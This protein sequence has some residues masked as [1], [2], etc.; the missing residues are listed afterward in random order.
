VVASRIGK[1]ALFI[2]GAN[3]HAAGRALGFDLDFKRLLL[4]FQSRG[5][6]VRAFYYTAIFENDTFSTLRPLLDWLDYNG[7]AVVTKGRREFID[8]SG[9][10][11]LKGNTDV[12]LAI[13][14]M[15]LADHVDQV[16]LFSGD[17]SFRSLVQAL[18]RKGVRVTVVS[19]ISS[20]PPMIASELRRQADVFEDLADLRD[21]IASPLH[22]QKTKPSAGI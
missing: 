7:F 5:T 12:E 16:V 22:R 14:A 10:R 13:D 15:E 6:L 17:G 3:T 4:E 9:N 18:Q 1:I 2:D 19:S 8:D 20:T 21:R 11:K